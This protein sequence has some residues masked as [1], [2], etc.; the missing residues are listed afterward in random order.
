MKWRGRLAGL[1][2]AA[3]VVALALQP[4]RIAE[5]SVERYLLSQLS[6]SLGLT[7]QTRA[8]GAFALLPT[9]RIIA[10]DVRLSTASGDVK[11]RIPRIRADIKLL[12]LLAG[13]VE[14]D[15]VVVIAPQVETVL[16]AGRV[17]PFAI[18]ISRALADLPS[19]P[20]I[21]IRENGSLFIRSGPGIASSA[22][23]VNM[24]ISAR[25][26]GD[27]LEARG[28][29]SWRGEAITFA[30]ASNSEKR[31]TLPMA[32]LQSPVLTLAFT[33]ARATAEAA[34]ADALEGSLDIKTPS[35]S[36]LGSWLST[37]SPVLLPLANTALSGRL[38]LTADG[39]QVREATLT[40]GNDALD[41]ALDWRKRDTR[42]RLTGT[43]AGKSLDIGRPEAG[44]DTARL[45]WSEGGA[46]AMLDVDKLLVHD[47]DLRF[48][49][50][51]VRL[52]HLTLTEVAGQLMAS[53]QR[54]DLSVTN[55]G[56][57][58]GSMR[59]RASIGRSQSGVEVRMQANADK[60]DLGLMSTD[61]FEA[62]RFTGV[63]A[64]QHQVEM[65]GDTMAALLASAQGRVSIAAR[66]GD[67]MGA[68][69]GDLMRRIERQP[70]NAVRDWRGG[71][72]SFEQFSASGVMNEGVLALTE[73]RGAGP[74]FKLALDGSVSLT[75]RSY[76]L[77]G[78]VLSATGII[79]LPFEVL[80]PLADPS[81]HINARS[82]IER[83]GA[84]APFIRRVD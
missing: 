73:A 8:D 43:F 17:D 25:D 64:M 63:G 27:A 61:L 53:E 16:P 34:G 20:H 30:F 74:A 36:R 32:Q 66:N 19:A 47:I 59:G 67:F 6:S 84:T 71:R 83:S 44:I 42:W 29:L 72:T 45:D 70:L 38:R 56:L 4:W 41:G 23:D 52:P 2:G 77:T 22:R 58:R 69:L 14:F 81:I 79:A 11:A 21:S 24:E 37:G 50:G 7:L 65:H 76:R 35:M 3:I 33:S 10:N 9:P 75:E 1:A 40:L 12:A 51:R 82:L 54:L 68:N 39:A 78:Q 5:R 13:R 31:D 55:A 46:N 28:S 48:S 49:L 57:Y 62:R 15:Q 18:I 26:K 60:V 80:G